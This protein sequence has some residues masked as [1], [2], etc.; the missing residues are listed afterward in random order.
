MRPGSL[1]GIVWSSHQRS[2]LAPAV[3]FVRLASLRARFQPWPITTMSW[4]NVLEGYARLSDPAAQLPKNVYLRSNE[5]TSVAHFRCHGLADYFASLSIFDG[6]EKAKY[7]FLVLRERFPSSPRSNSTHQ[8]PVASDLLS[9]SDAPTLCTARDPFE[10]SSGNVTGSDL[11]SLASLL[12]SSH[13]LEV[14]G[15]LKS[16]AGKVV[17]K[18]EEEMMESDGFKWPVNVGFH[19]SESMKSVFIPLQP[20][21]CSFTNPLN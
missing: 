12:K 2:T 17:S 15:S 5:Q 16:T 8:F 3:K 19:A 14:L 9:P 6:Y 7:H 13:A 21:F 4:S 1:R 18:I 11:G 10:G 20:L